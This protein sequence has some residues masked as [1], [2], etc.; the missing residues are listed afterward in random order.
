MLT[1]TITKISGTHHLFTYKRYDRDKT[2]E[3]ESREL[4][5][6]S[7]LAHDFLHY[8]VEMEAQTLD[9]F[10]GVLLR[11]KTYDDLL[12]LDAEAAGKMKVIEQI[13]GALTGI[14]KGVDVSGAPQYLKQAWELEGI[15][16]PAYFNERFIKRVAERYKKLIGEWKSTPYGETMTLKF[17]FERKA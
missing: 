11:G 10:Y 8:C 6:K 7:F 3:G 15:E 1:I 14:T 12:H 13:V 17:S 2:F 5:S 4:E 9:G 16:S